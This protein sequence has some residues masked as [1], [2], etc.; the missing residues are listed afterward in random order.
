LNKYTELLLQNHRMVKAGRDL[1]RSS[2]PTPLLSQCH[3]EPVAQDRVALFPS[4]FLSSVSFSWR[5]LSYLVQMYVSQEEIK[6]NP[7]LYPLHC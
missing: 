4:L 2:G 3:L 6:S 7:E 1:W 5:S